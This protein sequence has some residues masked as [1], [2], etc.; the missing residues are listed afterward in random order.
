[1]LSRLRETTLLYY[2]S[3]RNLC[4]FLRWDDFKLCSLTSLTQG[5]QGC[6]TLWN[7]NDIVNCLEWSEHEL[8]IY[9]GTYFVRPF[10]SALENDRKWNVALHWRVIW[11]K[12]TQVEVQ[13]CAWMKIVQLVKGGLL[14]RWLYK[15][16]LLCH[17]SIADFHRIFILQKLK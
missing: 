16:V 3:V 6:G 5:N 4:F 17:P 1:M 7:V 8:V 11:P 15:M 12:H 9:S 10:C 14:T 13:I 2:N